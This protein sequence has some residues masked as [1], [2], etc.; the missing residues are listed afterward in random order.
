[1]ARDPEFL[2]WA[3]LLTGLHQYEVVTDTEYVALTVMTARRSPHGARWHYTGTAD[4]LAAEA[5]VVQA[6]LRRPA[7]PARLHQTWLRLL[8]RM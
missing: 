4:D 2:L 8:G 1:V 3:D 5:A 6:L 7:W